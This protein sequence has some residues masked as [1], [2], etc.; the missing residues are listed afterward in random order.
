MQADLFEWADSRTI[1]DA[2]KVFHERALEA[3][4]Q[5]L[6]RHALGNQPVR[7]DGRIIQLPR[8]E[9]AA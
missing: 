1:I 2:T 9:K 6:V 7:R 4:A 3:L 5:N 8:P